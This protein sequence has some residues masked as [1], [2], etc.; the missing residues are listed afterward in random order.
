MKRRQ[1]GRGPAEWPRSV[2]A[3]HLLIRKRTQPVIT[4]FL[5]ITEGRTTEMVK[6]TEFDDVRG[7][8]ITIT[9]CGFVALNYIKP[10]SFLFEWHFW[11]HPSGSQS[12]VTRTWGAVCR[13]SVAEHKSSS[14]TC[15]QPC[16]F[17]VSVSSSVKW[18]S[19]STLVPG[20]FQRFKEI[21]Q[22]Q[23]GDS[24]GVTVVIPRHCIRSWVKKILTKRSSS[25]WKACVS[26]RNNK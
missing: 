15:S 14:V 18:G 25:F 10:T 5:P 4:C 19:H 23:S 9:L 13:V 7:G 1:K 17:S 6:H 21:N 26:L 24:M 2:T 12:P 8:V 20:L 16:R 22:V 3:M 11:A